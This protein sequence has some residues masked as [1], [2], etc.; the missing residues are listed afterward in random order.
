MQTYFIGI[1]IGTSNLKAIVTNAKGKTLQKYH[2]PCITLHPQ[3]NFAEQNPDDIFQKVIQLLNIVAQNLPKKPA[4]I[5][6]SA[7]MHSLISIDNNGHPLHDAIIWSDNRAEKEAN[8]LKISDLGKTIFLH[9]GTPI[10]PMSPLPKLLW[11]REHQPDIFEKTAWF[12]SIKEYVFYKFFRKKIIDLSIASATGLQDFE[13]KMWFSPAL[14]LANI[15]KNQLST[16]VSPYHQE[17]LGKNEWFS[18][19][20]DVPFVIGASDGALANLG[21]GAISD[22][23][24]TLTIGTSGAVRRTTKLPVRDENMQLFNYVLDENHY[25][26]G[27]PTNNGGIALEWFSKNLA[28]KSI[29]KLMRDAQKIP[30]GSDGLRFLPF[31]LGERA[32]IWDANARGAFLNIA[33]Q[34]TQAHFTRAVLEGILFNLQNIHALVEAQLAPTKAIY[35]DGGFT[36]S[37]FWVQMLADITGKTIFIRKNED[38]AAIGAIMMAMKSIGLY[39]NLEAMTAILKPATA[40]FP[41]LENH[42]KYEDL[43][44]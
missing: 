1:D 2:L 18:E 22:N 6:F 34:H 15:T 17:F 40:I 4:A 38:G 37:P 35:A 27:G 26:V 12:C 9:T 23:L 33:F 44:I 7:A 29:Q 19:W 30:I 36:K 42:Q 25:I 11:L 24:T 8:T 5:A 13:T 32:P 41:N 3:P 10:H 43:K 28:Q 31:I 16:I 20:E 39:E 14:D 21:A